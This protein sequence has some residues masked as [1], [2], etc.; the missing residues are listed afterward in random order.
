MDAD[1]AYEK[2][3]QRVEFTNEELERLLVAKEGE[4]MKDAQMSP[5]AGNPKRAGGLTKAVARSGLLLKGKNPGSIQRQEEDV[6]TRMLSASTAFEKA[7]NEFKSLRQD[8]FTNQLPRIIRVRFW[9][10]I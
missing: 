4:T 7:R 3:K 10:L 5:R 2:A 9:S 6:R 8:Y 1:T